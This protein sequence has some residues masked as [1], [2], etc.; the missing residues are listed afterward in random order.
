MNFKG[1]KMLSVLLSVLMLMSAFALGIS[2]EDTTCEHIFSNYVYD[3]NA[4]CYQDGTK[5]A[6]CEKC[7]AKNT[8]VDPQHLKTPHTY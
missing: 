4:T 7:S 3:N 2:A 1:K 8:V 5:T 6:V